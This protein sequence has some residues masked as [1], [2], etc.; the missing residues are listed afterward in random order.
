MFKVR[1]F[2]STTDAERLADMCSDV[3]NGTDYLPHIAQTFESDPLC[4]FVV[5]EEEGT[6]EMVAAG[7]LRS[8]DKDGGT[9]WIESIR[10][11]TKFKGRGIATT[12]LQEFVEKSKTKGVREILSCTISS[13]DAMLKVFGKAEMELAGNVHW[14]DFG[15]MVKFPGWATTDTE[16]K[17][18][19]IIDTLG[20]E[21]VVCAEAKG[22]K[23]Q[24]VESSEELNALLNKI[25]EEGGFGRLPGMGKVLG[26][27]EY[28]TESIK[29]GLVRRHASKPVVMALVKE[30]AIKSLRSKYVC[31]IAATNMHDIESALWEAC[32]D[33][34]ISL[35]ETG[36]AFCVA[37]DGCAFSKSS[38]STLIQSLPLRN[39]PFVLYRRML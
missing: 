25:Q 15:Q 29:K 3:W 27:S 36:P 5:M 4:D 10:V 31:S 30:P 24:T 20:L 33:E 34:I 32:S 26:D 9:V 1:P 6:G 14:C 13:N 11:S 22:E 35:L 12:L 2:S 17:A 18:A 28:L 7:N 39:D 37:M 16:V 38:P 19:N 23:W 8:F 21:D